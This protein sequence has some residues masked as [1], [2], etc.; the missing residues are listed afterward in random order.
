MLASPHGGIGGG[1]E[2]VQAVGVRLELVTCGLWLARRRLV[3]T[4]LGPGA[5]A[6]ARGIFRAHS[7]TTRAYG[8]TITST[9]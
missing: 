3:A 7:P 2:A 1:V 4:V 6:Q 9:A 5:R 8:A